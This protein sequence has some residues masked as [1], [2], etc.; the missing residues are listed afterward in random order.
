MPTEEQ[1]EQAAVAFQRF[2]LGARRSGLRTIASDPQ[3]ALLEELDHP[4]RARIRPRGLPD[5]RE[6]AAIGT[7]TFFEQQDVFLAENTARLKRQVSTPIGFLERLV[8]FWTSHFSMTVEKKG[9]IRAMAGQYER[10]V[11]RANLTG[12]FGQMLRDAILHPAMICY[13]DNTD[14]I[15]PNS[16]VGQET[17]KSGVTKLP[18]AIACAP[19]P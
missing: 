8:M 2:G 11:I 1:F 12:N 13:L 17:L 14:S 3:G 5:Y 18:P 16:P 10:D 15:G 7:R 6:A 9:H 19:M 4:V